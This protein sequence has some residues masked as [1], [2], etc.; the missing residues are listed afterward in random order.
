MKNS[1]KTTMEDVARAVGL[2]RTTVSFVLNDRPDVRIPASTRERVK[3]A[4]RELGYRPHSGSR[5]LSSQRTGQLGLVSEIVTGPLGS[6]TIRGIQ[7]AARQAGYSLFIVP[8]SASGQEDP[9]AFETLLK[10]G[11]DGILYATGR[12][13]RV[14]MPPQAQ[15]VPTVLV[16]C[17]DTSSDLPE[18]RPDE[19]SLGRLSAEALLEGHHRD[20]G[21]IELP[22]DGE[23]APGRRAGCQDCLARAGI[24]GE[25]VRSAVG[26]GTTRGGYAAAS[27]LM[28]AAPR[29]TA[30][31]CG[32]DRMAM[33]A[34]DALLERGLRVRD[35][36]AVIGIDDQE[37]IADQ[38]HPALT[39]VALPFEDMG[40][41]GVAHLLAL[42]AGEE[43]PARTLL[44]GRLVRRHSA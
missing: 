6:A 36:V 32:N 44:P 39:T 41:V 12:H 24:P 19:Y 42:I 18:V 21:V 8:T 11:V 20:I 4:A 28:D 34:Y 14:A 10:A 5:A 27:A 30:L 3:R 9:E 22:D 13:C 2:S 16:H 7:E 35:D 29:L 38:L 1:R 40:R 31:L 25:T 23:A 43:V 26:D 15:E 37:L 17:T 33:G